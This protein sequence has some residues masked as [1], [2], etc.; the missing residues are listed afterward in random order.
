MFGLSLSDML[1][2]S[3]TLKNGLVVLCSHI[4][5]HENVRHEVRKFELRIN[6]LKK[7]F[8]VMIWHPGTKKPTY[9]ND[10][11]DNGLYYPVKYELEGHKH[12]YNYDEGSFVI[13]MIERLVKKETKTPHNVDYIVLEYD[14][15]LSE[16]PY[17][18]YLTTDEGEKLKLKQVIK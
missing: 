16:I 17:C 3:F 10:V 12:L 11:E 9:S 7:T 18:L 2:K 1:P 4:E 14:D 8:D 15:T 13:S 6:T 5:E